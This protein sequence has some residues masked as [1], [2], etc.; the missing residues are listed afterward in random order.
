M[1]IAITCRAWSRRFANGD[2]WRVGLKVNG[3]RIQ[4]ACVAVASTMLTAGAWGMPPGYDPSADER[5]PRPS[6]LQPTTVES[7]E[8][9]QAGLAGAVSIGGTGAD[10]CGDVTVVDLP[11]GPAGDP[12]EVLLVGDTIDA[13]GPDC[14]RFGIASWWEAF[15]IDKCASVTIELCGSRPARFGASTELTESCR[16]DGTCSRFIQADDVSNEECLDN[17]VWMRF[18]SLPPGVYYYPL[19]AG[20]FYNLTIRA[21]QCVGDCDRCYGACCNTEERFCLDDVFVDGCHGV[22]RTWTFRQPCCEIECRPAGV[23]FDALGVELLSRVPL[24]AF[25]SGSERAMDVWGYTSPSGREYA[26]VGL[27]FGTGFVDITDPANPVVIADIPDAGSGTSDMAVFDQYAYNVNGNDSGIQIIDLTRIDDGVVTLLGSA[28]GGLTSAHNI[29]I[30]ETSGFAYP[31]ISNLTQGMVAFD[32]ADPTD[33]QLV[34]FWNEHQAHDV[35]VQTYDDCPYAGRSGAC[36]IAFVFAGEAGVMVVDVTEKGA[37]TTI[38][39]YTYDTVGYTHQGWLTDDLQ[40]LFFTDESDERQF[41]LDATTYVIDVSDVAN[42]KAVTTFT[43]G[44][45]SIDHNLMIRGNLAL[46]ANYAAGLRVLD[47]SDLSDIREIGHLDTYPHSNHAGFDGAWG[48]FGGFPSGTVIVT[49][50]VSGLFVASV[51]SVTNS[52]RGDFDGD[53]TVTLFDVARFEQCF[54]T[55]PTDTA[56]VLADLDCD[57]DIDLGDF[58][59]LLKRLDAE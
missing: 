15:R 52:R 54:R 23:E 27:T 26:I 59:Q 6:N 1:S 34:G 30:D 25:D 50:R 13:T 16:S 46:L 24:D 14:E 21:E 48:V 12:S 3:G 11:V 20:S 2:D 18:N 36:E 43:N 35:F 39:T 31:C 51:C 57:R 22:D 33:P 4:I 44:I 19:K 40:F 49:D 28:A 7:L 32:L 55:N 8:A 10:A 45:C 5:N 41:G 9:H 47:I 56:C 42:P 29:F 58:S 53:E 37:M 38:A 17:S